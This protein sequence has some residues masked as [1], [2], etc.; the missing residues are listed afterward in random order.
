[1]KVGDLVTHVMWNAEKGLILRVIGENK[2]LVQWLRRR[3]DHHPE[4]EEIEGVHLEVIS[5]SS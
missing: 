5:A 4:E 1:M 3:Y 2:Y